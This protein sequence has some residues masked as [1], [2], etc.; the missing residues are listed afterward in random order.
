MVSMI[1]YGGFLGLGG[2]VARMDLGTR[3]GLDHDGDAMTGEHLVACD[4]SAAA[5]LVER[6]VGNIARRPGQ[7]RGD[8][9]FGDLLGRR[10]PP[11]CRGRPR[12][13]QDEPR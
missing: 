2:E 7:R 10:R 11:S 6:I 5:S 9:P 12:C 1:R 4:A 13:R 3:T 8:P